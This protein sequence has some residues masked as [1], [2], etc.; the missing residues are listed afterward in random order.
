MFRTIYAEYGNVERFLRRGL[1][2]NQKTVTDLQSKYL[3]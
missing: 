1:Y 2:L 3:I